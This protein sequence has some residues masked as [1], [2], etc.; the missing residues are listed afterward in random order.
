MSLELHVSF[1]LSSFTSFQFFHLLPILSPIP[2]FFHFSILSHLPYS[3]ISS[4]PLNTLARRRI[5]YVRRS[6]RRR[7]ESRSDRLREAER[8]RG[9]RAISH[10]SQN[11]SDTLCCTRGGSRRITPACFLFNY[12]NTTR[13]APV[14]WGH[15]L[16][17][18]RWITSL[19]AAAS[20]KLIK[21]L[22]SL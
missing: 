16:F 7:R 1:I 6:L 5:H 8:W 3:F 10:L 18:A 13:R 4:L 2:S 14:K 15:L 19:E 22:P 21:W 11:R 17:S 20:S 12:T 9:R